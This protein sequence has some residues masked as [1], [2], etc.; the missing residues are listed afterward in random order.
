MKFILNSLFAILLSAMPL[1]AT[2][3]ANNN[4]ENEFDTQ[5][6]TPQVLLNVLNFYENRFHVEAE[7]NGAAA[8][9]VD[10]GFY[11]STGLAHDE[12]RISV[13]N[14]DAMSLSEL[15]GIDINGINF[16]PLHIGGSFAITAELPHEY[17]KILTVKSYIVTRDGKETA[18]PIKKGIE[19]SG[20]RDRF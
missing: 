15:L 6:Q 5:P 13:L 3:P 9:I 20:G 11:I 16:S 1:M 4:A 2:S 7:I 18:S 10:Y 14:K 12:V 19:L 17:H 8:E